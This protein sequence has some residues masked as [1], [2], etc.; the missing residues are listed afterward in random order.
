[1]IQWLLVCSQYYQP[2]L[3]NFRAFSSSQNKIPRQTEQPLPFRPL[4]LWPPA[5]FLSWTC[6][7]W[8]F[9]L[10]EVTQHV[11]LR[12]APSL[13][14][15]LSKRLPAVEI[16]PASVSM[17]STDPTA[18]RLLVV[19]DAATNVYVPVTCEC[20]FFASRPLGLELLDHVCNFWKNSAVSH[21]GGN[22]LFP[23]AI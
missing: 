10:N 1:M 3:P 6:L 17:L 21:G 4:R 5:C 16:S 13:R 14:G 20:R 19:N 8:A 15:M 2:S 23:P 18:H 7:F 11:A 9:P 22:I 12:L